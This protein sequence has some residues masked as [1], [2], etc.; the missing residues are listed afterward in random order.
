MIILFTLI[1]IVGILTMIWLSQSTVHALRRE[2]KELRE[3]LWMHR[4][5]SCNPNVVT[6]H[7]GGHRYDRQPDGSWHRSEESSREEW[8][9]VDLSELRGVIPPPE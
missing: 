7:H 1:T 5:A 8:F 2:N 4:Y 9:D 6:F 3:L